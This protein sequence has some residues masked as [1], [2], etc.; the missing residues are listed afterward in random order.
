M[1]LSNYQSTRTINV[2]YIWDA[3]GNI[4]PNINIPHIV[5]LKFSI[6]QELHVFNALSSWNI[7]NMS[8]LNWG[9][10]EIARM[11]I[12]DTS[13]LLEQYRDLPVPFYH[14]VLYWES[15]RRLEVVFATLEIFEP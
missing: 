15:S 13:P 9:A 4:R 6:V 14:A 3:E 12:T 7:L 8:E 11:A 1:E 5:V 10:N 2:N